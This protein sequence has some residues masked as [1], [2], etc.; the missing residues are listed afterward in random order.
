MAES[1]PKIFKGVQEVC[2]QSKANVPFMRRT[3]QGM[4]SESKFLGIKRNIVAQK[5][6]PAGGESPPRITPQATW[7]HC[8]QNGEERRWSVYVRQGVDEEEDLQQQEGERSRLDP[9]P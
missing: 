3:V 1:G 9:W 4:K 2:P 8:R 5:T 6:S 7:D